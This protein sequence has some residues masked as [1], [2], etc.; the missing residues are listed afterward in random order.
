MNADK[1]TTAIVLA[2]GRGERSGLEE[3]KQ[4]LDLAGAPLIIHCLRAFNEASE[5]DKIIVVTHESY[6]ERVKSLIDSYTIDKC[7]RVVQGG[8]TRQDSSRAGVLA[9]DEN[10]DI[11]L[12]H[13]AARPFVTTEIITNVVEALSVC[14]AVNP[15]ISSTDT[16]VRTNDK[17][18]IEE[19]LDRKQILG[20]QTPQG[21]DYNLVKQAHDHALAKGIRDHTDD[22][23]LILAMGKPVYTVTGDKYNIK[24]TYKADF[25]IAEV[26]FK[27]L[28][29]GSID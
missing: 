23:S 29:N 22:G 9:A 5:V 20:C 12:I 13:D 15:V 18:F 21:F 1:K 17:G 25:A 11:V 4:F 10:T 26:I 19:I 14:G 16:V 28:S 6:M 3:P 8:E 7:R 27:L 2:A 24:L